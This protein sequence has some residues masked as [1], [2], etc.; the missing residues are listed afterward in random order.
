MNHI[1]THTVIPLIFWII[2]WILVMM[3][4]IYMSW[5]AEEI[6]N[7]YSLLSSYDQSCSE[8]RQS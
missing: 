3:S 2:L 6:H 4:I 8:E 1:I 7:T 5:V